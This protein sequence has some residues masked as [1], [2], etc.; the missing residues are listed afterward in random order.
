MT[1]CTIR[2]LFPVERGLHWR[3]K[4]KTPEGTSH[5][6]TDV[7][8]RYKTSEKTY[9]IMGNPFGVSYF[10]LTP[11][12]LYHRGV[13]P[14]DDVKKV[15]FYKG[16]DIIRLEVPLSARNRWSGGASIE[17]N[18]RT[19]TTY[20]NTEILGWG[21]IEVPAGTF[22]ALVTS[23]TKTTVFVEKEAHLGKGAIVREHIWYAPQIGVVRRLSFLFHK[24]S[25]YTLLRDDTLEEFTREKKATSKK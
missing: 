14:A 11:Q 7:F 8:G 6:A 20:Y 13:A 12:A 17:K 19:I 15:K 4:H 23:S 22:D 3:Y 1:T 9:F 10:E 21:K 2:A 18:G 25:G 5:Y 24:E 16:G